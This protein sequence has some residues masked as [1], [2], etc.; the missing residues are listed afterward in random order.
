MN[1][2]KTVFGLLFGF[3]SCTMTPSGIDVP[4]GAKLALI[5]G[6]LIDGTGAAAVENAVLAIG[7]DGKI[8]AV[9]RRGN[10]PIPSE[11]T[12]IDVK[13]A[14]VLPGFINAHVHDA[15]SAPNLE[16]WAAA[17]VTT[18]RDEG[19]N[20]QDFSLAALIAQRNGE[21]NQPRY[22]RLISAGWIITAP[23]GYGRLGVAS[24]EEARQCVTAELDAGADLI[25]VAVED[26]ALIFR[27]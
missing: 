18:V 9:G 10:A 12:V 14:T 4:P 27:K 21:W 7:N 26:G 8:V 22:A 2:K 20:N 15:Y 13:G 3:V 24:A 25:K 19:I 6:T 16:A 17:G 5:N 11:I 1:W 23:G